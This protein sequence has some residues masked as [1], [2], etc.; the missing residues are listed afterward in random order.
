MKNNCNVARDLMPLCIDGA[1]SEE[2][3]QYVD[4]HVAE[5]GE[6]A[7]YFAQIHAELPTPV[8]MQE[9][10]QMNAA[11]KKIKLQRI[12]RALI[13]AVLGIVMG[14]LTYLAV[15]NF[16]ELKFRAKY[17]HWNGDLKFDAVYTEVFKQRNGC[18]T[19]ML[20]SIQSGKPCYECDLDII[21]TDD[22]KGV[23]VQFR[24]SYR[25]FDSDEWDWASVC[26]IGNAGEEVWT[27]SIS[28]D[29]KVPILWV[30]VVSGNE[31]RVIWR[32]GD[33]PKTDDEVREYLAQFGY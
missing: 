23:Y 31:T 22:G 4:E 2:S 13:A 27:L 28:D 25:G 26:L 32:Q 33:T 19:I 9:Q 16:D 5:C 30:E 6:C 18:W 15:T 14:V 24:F 11:A 10:E 3:Q 1:A 20:N 29:E 21:D 12:R 7:D 17:V 8:D